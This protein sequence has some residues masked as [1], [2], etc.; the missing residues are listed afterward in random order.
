MNLNRLRLVCEFNSYFIFRAK[1]LLH[2]DSELQ[3]LDK[4]LLKCPCFCLIKKYNFISLD[5]YMFI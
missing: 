5:S 4:V 1:C 2:L 3:F